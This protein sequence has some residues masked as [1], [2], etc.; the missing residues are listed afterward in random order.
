MKE[1]EIGRGLQSLIL[2]VNWMLISVKQWNRLAPILVKLTS[3]KI[4]IQYG[5][6]KEEEGKYAEAAGAYE[7]AKDYDSV[8]R[9][10]IDHLQDIEG[11]AALVRQTQARESAK[12]LAANYL[13]S[14]NFE[15]AI[16]FYLIAG[17]QTQALELAKQ[18]D[19][20]EFFAGAVKEVASTDLCIHNI[21]RSDRDSKILRVE[22]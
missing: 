6:A 4:F 19:Y 13:Q 15:H 11:G 1:W 9:I 17:M 12:L 3:P 7:R 5:N 20:M 14:R 22:G 18:Q 10:L 21:N 8:I 16:E 2:R